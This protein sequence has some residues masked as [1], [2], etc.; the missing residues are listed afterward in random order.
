MTREQRQYAQRRA[1]NLCSRCGKIAPV[2]NR[3]NCATCQ[4]KQQSSQA[5]SNRTKQRKRRASLMATSSRPYL[6]PRW[7]PVSGSLALNMVRNGR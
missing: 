2:P 3:V 4:V 1:A 7:S 5:V 6:L